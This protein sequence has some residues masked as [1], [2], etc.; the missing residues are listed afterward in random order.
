MKNKLSDISKY[1]KLEK[2][3]NDKQIVAFLVCLL[4]A[5]VLWFLNALSKDYTATVSYPVKYVNPP[6]HRFLS[7]TPPDKFDLKVEAHGFTLLRHK[8]SLSFSPIILNLSAVTRNVESNSGSYTIRTEDLIRRIADQ[9]SKEITISEIR[10]EFITLVLDS[11][12]TKK[13]PVKLNIKTEFKP[14]FYL[15]EPLSASPDSVKITGP[16]TILDTIWS[17]KTEQKTFERLDAQIERPVDLLHPGK[18]NISPEKVIIKVP[19]ERFTEKELKIPVEVRN[20]PKNVNIKLF[21]SEVKIFFLVGLSEF[22]SITTADFKAYV[23]YETIILNNSE[24]LEVKIDTKPTYIQMQRI[25]PGTV[26][27]LIE[28]D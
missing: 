15:K 12:I 7:N 17:L 18:T 3:K 24:E 6:S 9:V 22:E 21:P 2:I 10:P 4:I 8:L 1:I 20:K 23:D 19:V 14:Q 27:Y 16:A 5:T 25:S 13:V 26:E 11:L 28:T